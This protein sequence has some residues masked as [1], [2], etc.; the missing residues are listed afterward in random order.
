MTVSP[1][2]TIN[3]NFSTN[4]QTY[5]IVIGQGILNDLVNYLDYQKYTRICL[6]IDENVKQKLFT[7]DLINK[8][9]KGFEFTPIQRKVEQNS[10][11]DDDF[12]MEVVVPSG[13]EFKCL[14]TV[15]NLWSKFLE[16]NLDRK[17][18]IVNIGGGVIGDMG[19]FAAS[20]YMRGIDFI[21]VPTTLLSQVDASV[22]GKTGFDYQGIKNIIGTFTQPK[23]VLIDV[24]T[25][26]TLPQRE[27]IAGVAEIIKHGLIFDRS[28]FEKLV[29]HDFTGPSFEGL[30]DIIYES[31]LIKSK[32][33]EQD[34]RESGLRKILN[35]GHTIGH[36]VETY[37]LKTGNPLL[38]GEA[39]G[40][41]ML[42]ES[43][44]S[45]EEGIITQGDFDLIKKVI[46]EKGLPI[47]YYFEKEEVLEL[48]RFD[49][50]NEGQK[51]NWTLL[52]AIGEAV[53]DYQPKKE[54]I[55]LG[56]QE[57]LSE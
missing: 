14:Q 29:N 15:D 39:V 10:Q 20:C 13:E 49:K 33:V 35:F 28:Y 38:H 36:A 18:L 52:Q 11:T 23:K 25:L 32:I 47:S 21:Q 53:F 54:S 45:L 16:F 42:A 55:E 2:K 41:G 7:E 8:I 40:L 51:Q 17:S 22:G 27:L 5:Q 48:I 44:V 50:K 56:L 43:R 24:D 3:L 30:I 9:K 6:I 26:K 12:L 4:S 31:C 37:S 57:I 1:L 19:G 34:E 46:Q